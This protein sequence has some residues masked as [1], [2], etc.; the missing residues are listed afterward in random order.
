M[1]VLSRKIGQEII[2]GDQ[3][4]VTVVSVKGNQVRLGITA[5]KDIP[6]LR[7]EIACQRG[8]QVPKKVASKPLSSCACT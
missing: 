1:L 2:V 3:I 7:E 4:R 6:V 5:A 8:V